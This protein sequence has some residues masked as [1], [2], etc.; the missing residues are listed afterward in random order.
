[1]ELTHNALQLQQQCLSLA[2]AHPD[3]AFWCAQVKLKRGLGL[4][5]EMR[6]L[7]W[8]LSLTRNGIGPSEAE[9]DTVRGA[10][11][12]PEEVTLTRG[13]CQSKAGTVKIVRIKWGRYQQKGLFNNE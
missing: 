12:V 1:M 6:D 3:L 5:L 9:I 10:F 4:T 7:S 11:N 2:E 8:T 13:L